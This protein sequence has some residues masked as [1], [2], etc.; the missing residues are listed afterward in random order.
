MLLCFMRLEFK[1]WSD[2][3]H[4]IYRI[5]HGLIAISLLPFFLVFLEL[6]VTSIKESR[7]SE[8]ISFAILLS[9]LPAC[10]FF[11]WDVWKGHRFEYNLNKEVGLKS[12]L[13]LFRR[14][15]VKRYLWLE[16]A[17]VLSLVGLWLTAHYLFVV[18]YFA[19]LAQFS[20][21]RPSEDR[22]IRNLKLTKAEREALHDSEY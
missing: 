13:I 7:V 22:V 8:W 17:C 5:Y 19:I 21:L 12:Q 1:N 14:I 16:V 4:Q 15:E 2:F 18:A 3:H 20:F 6:E 9:F 10:F 11:S